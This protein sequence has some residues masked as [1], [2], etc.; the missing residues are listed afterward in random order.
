[1]S[2]FSGSPRSFHFSDGPLSPLG[3][4]G[5]ADSPGTSALPSPRSVKPPKKKSSSSFFNFLSVKEPSTQAFEAYQEQM[6]KRGTTQTGRANAVGLPGVSSAKLPPTVPKVNSKWDGVPQ[7][8]KDR[9]SKDVNMDRQSLY[10]ATSRPLHTSRSTG[11][12]MTGMTSSSTSSKSSTGSATRGN[13]KLKLE[14]DNLS[15]MYGWEPSSQSNRS[16]TLSIPLEPRGSTSSAPTLCRDTSM[17]FSSRPPEIAESTN[18]LPANMPPPLD[19]SSNLSSPMISPATPPP[20]TPNGSLHALPL[21]PRVGY[22][23]YTSPAPKSSN[24][25]NEGVIL[26]SSGINVLGPPASGTYRPEPARQHPTRANPGMGTSADDLTERPSTQPGS[27]LKRPPLIPD[28]I[29]PVPPPPT[30]DVDGDMTVRSPA[31]ASGTK[32]RF[33]SMFSKGT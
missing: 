8:A 12:N 21:S 25:K 13:G 6:K 28:E 14:H 9:A 10:A 20:L 1:M 7:P 26:T 17:S 16:S 23:G 2:S 3:L 27:I 18:E 33:R 24:T 32:L 19:P 15:N 31:T 11:S 29:W 4:D 22:P 5:A 30:T